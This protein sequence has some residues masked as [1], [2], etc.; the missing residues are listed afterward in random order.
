MQMWC[1]GEAGDRPSHILTGK[2][3]IAIISSSRLQTTLHS[4]LSLNIKSLGS[5]TGKAGSPIYKGGGGR[6]GGPF[7]G[8]FRQSSPESASLPVAALV[9]A[10]ELGSFV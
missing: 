10:W 7:F 6:S 9:V 4:L 3:E 1:S 5:D 8:G 2:S